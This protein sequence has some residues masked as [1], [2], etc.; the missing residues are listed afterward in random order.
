M[1]CFH[2]FAI[3]QPRR[4]ACLVP[5]KT[6]LLQTRHHRGSDE[7][8]LLLSSSKTK[9]YAPPPECGALNSFR[10]RVY[11]NC[12]VSLSALATFPKKNINLLVDRSHPRSFFSCTYELQI[13]QLLSFYI[14]ASDGGCRGGSR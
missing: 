9:P 12:R 13:F 1:L 4:S 11:K 7:N 14:H 3:L 8:Q 10:M 6:L 5:P 2:V